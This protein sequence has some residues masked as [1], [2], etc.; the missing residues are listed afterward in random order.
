MTHVYHT[1][2]NVRHRLQASCSSIKETKKCCGSRAQLPASEVQDIADF[3]GDSLALSRKAAT[4]ESDIILFC[5]VHFM[6]E[7]ASILCPDKKFSYQTLRLDAR[8]LLQ[9]T[10]G[11]CKPGRQSTLM[12]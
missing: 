10:L 6:A 9:L 3:I 8:L 7:T 12:L 5:G 11:S 2:D 4:A 1:H